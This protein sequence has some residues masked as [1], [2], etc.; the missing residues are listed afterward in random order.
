M[1]VG[2]AHAVVIVSV[3]PPEIVPISPVASSTMYRLHVPLGSVPLKIER[4]EPPRGA[5]AGA[6]HVSPVP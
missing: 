6:G 3:Q 1:G 2:D 5:G 4:A